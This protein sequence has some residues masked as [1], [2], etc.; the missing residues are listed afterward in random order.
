M[1]EPSID[2]WFADWLQGED[3]PADEL[4]KLGDFKRVE[5][6][7]WESNGATYVPFVR[8][9]CHFTAISLTGLSF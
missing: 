6:T 1:E 8:H 4:A 7:Q 3:I 9:H 2:T 5:D